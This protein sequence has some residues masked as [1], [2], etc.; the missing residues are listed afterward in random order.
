M[1]A[2]PPYQDLMKRA[3]TRADTYDPA[4]CELAVEVLRSFGTLR[5]AATGWSMLPSIWPGETLVVEK[6]S[7][8]QVGVGDV[9]LVGREGRLRAH[10]V[11]GTTGKEESR[12]W[13]TRGDAL[14]AS[15]HPVAANELLGRVTYLIRGGKLVA[16]PA[17]LGAIDNLIAEVVRRST[18]AARA[19]VYL[20]RI[21]QV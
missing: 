19:F 16:L 2:E 1:L 14:A 21:R 7:P 18:P 12:R 20:N 8:D 13:I 5:F 9:V 15:D 11:V 3:D 17:K 4:K 6:A 10:R